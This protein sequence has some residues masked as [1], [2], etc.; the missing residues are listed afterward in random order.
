[1]KIISKAK[2]KLK[3]IFRTHFEPFW[4]QNQ[5]KY[6]AYLREQI[7][8]Q[9]NKMIHCADPQQGYI[10][11]K[12][13][14]CGE[15]K[16]IGFT[17]KSR[18]CN[19]C[20][21]RYSDEWSDKQKAKLW[22]VIHRHCVFTIP[23]EFRSHFFHHKEN[24]KDL[25]D[26]AY[27]VIEETINHVNKK[28]RNKYDKK[29]RRK[30]KDLLWQTGMISVVHTF[31]RDLK[32]N[33]HIH[34]LVPEIK[35]KGQE[36]GKLN[37]FNYQSLRK[38]WQ[39]KLI[40]YMMEKNPRKKKEYSSYFTRYPDGFYVYA[41]GKMKNAKKSAQYIGRYL[42][43]PAMAEHR[44]IDINQDQITYWYIDHHSKKREEVQESIE[45]FM[46]KLIM[47]IPAKHQKLVRRYG[48][49]AGRTGLSNK[50]TYG[51]LQ[52]IQSDRQRNHY[53]KI[54]WWKAKAP[55]RSYRQRLMEN[56]SKDPC[57]CDKCHGTMELWEIWHP[58]YGKLYELIPKPMKRSEEPCMKMT[59]YLSPL[60]QTYQWSISD[61]DVNGADSK[62]ALTQISSTRCAH[63]KTVTR[64][65]TQQRYA[66]SVMES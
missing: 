61:S 25:Q 48:I 1:M 15:E 52:Y 59:N 22:D 58:K 50:K 3:D 51:L 19:S 20:G 21:K 10:K 14:K 42:A 46:G 40:S 49:Y 18:F 47:H 60:E 34:A 56:F 31:G 45:S 65:E 35:I 29:K 28:N 57:Q 9:V 44:I 53:T 7:W 24:L 39:Y 27:Q 66:S 26:M 63:Q 16:A 6:P 5:Q 55:K 62:K 30:Q 36:L 43:R 32:Y 17:C 54:S 37:Y 8:T 38:I 33:P 64:M 12:C 11:Y 2:Y 4:A 41:E 23:E 13:T